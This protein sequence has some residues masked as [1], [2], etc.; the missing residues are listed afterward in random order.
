[1]DGAL[2]DG[3]Y[4]VITEGVEGA[5]YEIVY[6]FTHGCANKDTATATV[7]EVIEGF[8]FDDFC[9]GSESPAPSPMARLA[10][11]QWSI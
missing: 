11:F 9:Y 6:S 10:F 1:M 4:G 7:I 8:T 2:I 5:T 3:T